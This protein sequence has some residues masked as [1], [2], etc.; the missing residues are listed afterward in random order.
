MSERTASTFRKGELVERFWLRV[1]KTQGC[2]LWTGSKDPYGYGYLKV[3]RK[4]RV[5]G[6]RLSYELAKG[7]ISKDKEIDHLCHNPGC[8]NPSHLEAVSHAENIR[9]GLALRKTCPRGHPL[10]PGNLVLSKYARGDR[11]CLICYRASQALWRETHREAKREA[12][13]AYYRRRKGIV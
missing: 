5:I 8:V 10:E 9:R 4:G 12:D 6:H 2:W 7:P 13:R 11:N 1:N 3:G